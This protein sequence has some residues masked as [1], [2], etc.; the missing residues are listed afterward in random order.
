MDFG[1]IIICFM[2]IVAI[3]AVVVLAGVI[4]INV[5]DR[6]YAPQ[7]ELCT[8]VH[9]VE[10]TGYFYTTEGF[11]FYAEN[12]GIREYLKA[13]QDTPLQL[14]IRRGISNDYIIDEKSY[15]VKYA[16]AHRIPEGYVGTC[17]GVN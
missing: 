10:Q 9:F 2:G 6:G 15:M 3:C 4:T 7:S 17:N 13:H 5:H 16:N 8:S 14:T 12:S 1:E 11:M